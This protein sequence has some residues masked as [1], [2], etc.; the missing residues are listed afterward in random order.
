MPPNSISAPP[1]VLSEALLDEAGTTDAVLNRKNIN[2]KESATG[3][4]FEYDAETVDGG[5]VKDIAK[6]KKAEK[7][8]L[9]LVWRNIIAFG[10]LHLA[11]VY[12]AYL[13]VTSA[14]WQTIVFGK[15]YCIW[16]SSNGWLC[17]GGVVLLL[18]GNCFCVRNNP[19]INCAE[20]LVSFWFS[21]WI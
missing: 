21:F 20:L 2:H 3:V 4:L 17:P 9:N 12:G 7:R 8:K 1:Q 11:A 5:L 19:S 18:S 15:F 13:M 16:F 14:K 10:Y 6:L